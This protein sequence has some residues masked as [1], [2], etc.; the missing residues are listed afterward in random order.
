MQILDAMN[1]YSQCQLSS[2]QVDGG[3]IEN[4]L[5]LQLLA[6][7]LGIDVGENF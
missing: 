6:D 7:I 3:M 2:V 1:E 4:K 5:M